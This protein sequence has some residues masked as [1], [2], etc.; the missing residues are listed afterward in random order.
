MDKQKRDPLIEKL[1][2]YIS[3]NNL[4]YSEVANQLGVSYRS[5]Y[6]WLDYEYK[7]IGLYRKAIENLLKGE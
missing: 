5:I 6:R 3:E 7:P 4:S 2:R 1:R